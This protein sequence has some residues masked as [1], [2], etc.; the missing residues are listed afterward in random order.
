[1][2]ICVVCICEVCVLLCETLDLKPGEN[3]TL[4]CSN[5]CDNAKTSEEFTGMYLYRD[6]RRVAYYNN[7]PDKFVPSHREDVHR[8]VRSGVFERN[9]ITIRNVSVHDSGFYRCSYYINLKCEA[10]CDMYSVSGSERK[11]GNEK[12]NHCSSK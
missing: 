8:I 10:V 4:E 6:H 3:L 7:N 9:K 5:D 11:E 12:I 1:M 2:I